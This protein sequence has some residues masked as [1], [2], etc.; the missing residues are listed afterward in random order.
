MNFVA[1]GNVEKIIEYS[2]N[3]KEYLFKLEKNRNYQPGSFA[4]LTLDKVTASDRWP[5]SRTFSIASYKKGFM[6]FIIKREGEYTS[7]ILDTLG[8]GSN[9]TLKFPFGD[10]YDE[11][12]DKKHIVI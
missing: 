9:V 1:N 10:L 4:Q 6:R 5:E 11:T 3:L 12:L 8:E 2:S 7:K